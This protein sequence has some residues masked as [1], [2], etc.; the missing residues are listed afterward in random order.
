MSIQ[1]YADYVNRELYSI[2]KKSNFIESFY[3]EW[4]KEVDF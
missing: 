3:P 1:V 4:Y 2:I